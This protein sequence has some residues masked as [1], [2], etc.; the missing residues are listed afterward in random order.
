[1]VM[2]LFQTQKAFKIRSVHIA[3]Q[4]SRSTIKR[5]LPAMT[6]DT[7]C[8]IDRY[9][10]SKEY[11]KLVVETVILWMIPGASPV[12]SS[13]KGAIKHGDEVEV[14]AT[15]KYKGNLWAKVKCTAYEKEQTGWLSANLLKDLGNPE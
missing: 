10:D 14:I 3:K 1:M 6:V 4:M 11:G 2:S 9:K 13:V 5:C 7:I 15:Q 8:G 12:P